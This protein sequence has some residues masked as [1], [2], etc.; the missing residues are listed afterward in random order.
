MREPLHLYS[1]D[2]PSVFY[3]DNMADKD[4]LETCFPSLQENVV[5]VE[6]YSDLE[7]LIIPSDVQISIL[8]STDEI[9]AAMQSILQLLPNDDTTGVVVAALDSEWNVEVSEHGFVTGR[10]QTAV[11]QI[12]VGK[13]IY[14]IQVS[15]SF[16]TIK[17]YYKNTSDWSTTG[18]KAASSYSEAGLVQ[19]TNPKGWAV[20]DF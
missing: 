19:S 8:K 9:N 6:K 13:H 1:H 15:H 16:F 3:T 12:A 17:C 14:V 20:C 10:G 4:L 7:A 2:Q 11:L 18:W 5:P